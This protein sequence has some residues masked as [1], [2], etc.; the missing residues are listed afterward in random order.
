MKLIGPFKQIITLRNIDLKG[1][2]GDEA[3]EIIKDGGIIVND[4]TIVALGDFESIF[5]Q[6]KSEI[7]TVKE[8]TTD[9]VL[10]PGLVDMHTHICF[11]GTRSRDYAMRNAGKTY[12]EIAKEGGGI[13][14]TVNATRDATREELEELTLSRVKRH[15]RNGVTTMEI[16]SG[17]GLSFGQEIKM[18]KVIEDVIPQT[19]ATIIPTCLA[20]HIFPKDYD[21]TVQEYLAEIVEKLFPVLRSE[22][23]CNRIDAFIEEEAFNAKNIAPYFEAAQRMGFDITVHADQF[24]PGGTEVAVKYNALS[25]DHLEAS[26][27]KEIQLLASSNVVAVAL[28]GATL[29]LGCAFT[30]A[31]KLL[32]AGC[33]LAIASDWNPGSGPM[34][35]L[36]TSASILQTF[37]KL[38]TAE[39]LSGMTFRAAHA[40]NLKDRGT[41]DKGMKADFISFPVNDYREIL[42]QQ[43]QLK[44]SK[45]WIDGERQ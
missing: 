13:M 33:S 45:V 42:Y 10:V 26:G 22:K 38:S 11:A 24:H 30:P 15:I 25:A 40:L 43:G 1:P 23:L 34:G 16:K 2:V 36:V 8:I 29:G 31:R 32:D 3:L 39:V 28:P 41:L 12:L 20:A 14:D 4:K 7:K 18:L 21:G 35:D 17:Y 19:A 27:D 6:Y 5:K 9:Q 44:P 37:Q